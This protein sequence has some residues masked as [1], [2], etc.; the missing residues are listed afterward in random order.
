MRDGQ[1]PNGKTLKRSADEQLPLYSTSGKE[2]HAHMVLCDQH[3]LR[4]S[5]F[6]ASNVLPGILSSATHSEV[7]S[8][9]TTTTIATA[10]PTVSTLLFLL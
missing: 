2:H 5:A 9:P 3:A 7:L 4:P 10:A 1:V 6:V 8:S